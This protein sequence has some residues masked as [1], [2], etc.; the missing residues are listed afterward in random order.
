MTPPWQVSASRF[1]AELD[2]GEAKKLWRSL[3][4]AQKQRIVEQIV[5]NNAGPALRSGRKTAPLHA[6]RTSSSPKTAAPSPCVSE[7]GGVNPVCAQRLLQANM[8]RYN[9]SVATA[10]AANAATAGPTRKLTKT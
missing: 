10:A 2:N 5:Y 8:R 3:S 4:E 6:S 7:D 9:A 1:E